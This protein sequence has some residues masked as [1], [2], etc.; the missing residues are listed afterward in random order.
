MSSQLTG[1]PDRRVLG[2]LALLFAFLLGLFLWSQA[3]PADKSKRDNKVFLMS[4]IPLQWGEADMS[5]IARGEAEPSPLFEKLAEAN[6]VTII[7]DFQKLGRPKSSMLLLVQ[8]RALAPRELAELDG[9]IRSGGSALIFADP[10]LDWPSERPLGDPGRPLFTSLLTPMLG[11][12]G[13]ELALPV[14][15]EAE[16]RQAKMGEYSIALR[17]A[18]IWLVAGKQPSAKCAIREDQLAAFCKVGKGR[19]LLVAD[20]DMLHQDHWTDGLLAEGT[21]GWL[22][23][24]INALCDTD[25]AFPTRLWDFEGK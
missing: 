17:S 10:A 3:A 11:H 22:Q 13:L 25:S 19:A 20:A 12:W 21:M 1:L 23:A 6:S 5:E 4:S 18:G 15:E 24:V 7:D 16:D 8:P 9:W 2:A 14:S